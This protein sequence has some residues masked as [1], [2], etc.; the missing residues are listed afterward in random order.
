MQ[1]PVARG[2]VAADRIALADKKDIRKLTEDDRFLMATGDKVPVFGDPSFKRFVQYFWCSETLPL[3]KKGDTGYVV[4]LPNRKIDGSLGV[5]KG[6]VKPDADVHIGYLPFTKRN[7]LTQLFKLLH[8]RYGWADE[9]NKRDCSG[10]HR[11]VL[12]CFDIV[13]GRWPNFVLLASDHQTYINPGLSTE[14]KIEQVSTIE[15][16]ITW[17]GTSG[18]LVFYLGKARNGKLYFMHNGG[19]GYDEGDQ[20]FYV[21]RV[22]INEAHH[23]WYNI[24]SPRVFTTFRK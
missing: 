20:H 1:T 24:N 7:V 3:L 11:V 4:K 17:C 6:Y 18:H 14:E 5:S 10:T 16:D 22:D 2:W 12:Q 23:S 15:G 8:T 9:F 21:N 19:W 13:T